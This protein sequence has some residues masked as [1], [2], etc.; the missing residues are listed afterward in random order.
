MLSGP[1]KVINENVWVHKKGEF[2]EVFFF[3][4]NET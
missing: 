1:F 3:K 2:T 4:T